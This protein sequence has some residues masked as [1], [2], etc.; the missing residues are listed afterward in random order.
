MPMPPG[1]GPEGEVRRRS[2]EQF[3]LLEA[4]APIIAHLPV[5]KAKGGMAQVDGRESFSYNDVY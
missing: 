1:V 2:M 3:L 4:C 5:E